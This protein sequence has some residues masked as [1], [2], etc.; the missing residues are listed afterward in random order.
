M[1]IPTPPP[2]R[3]T[4]LP[5]SHH[6][7][8]TV[9]ETPPPPPPHNNKPSPF[10]HKRDSGFV[11]GT[12]VVSQ[13]Y[14]YGGSSADGEILHTKSNSGDSA[15]VHSTAVRLA[16]KSN[17]ADGCVMRRPTLDEEEEED[18]VRYEWYWGP[19]SREECG[20]QLKERGQIGNFIVRKNDRGDF[21]MSFW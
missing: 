21:V 7:M 15:I 17:S 8:S 4:T 13:G 18:L 1:D 10:S 14:R 2:H 20:R 11:S 3:T 12:G 6:I 16:D 9:H 19:M 5:H